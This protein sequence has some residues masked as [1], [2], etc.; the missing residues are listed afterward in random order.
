MR[1]RSNFFFALVAVVCVG[2]AGCGSEGP[3]A[4]VVDTVPP[5]AVE[6]VTATLVGGSIEVQW[7]AASEADVVGYHVFRSVNGTPAELLG[8]VVTNA[9]TDVSLGAG[10]GFRYQIA[11]YDA[12]GNIGVTTSSTTVVRDTTTGSGPRGEIRD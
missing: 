8:S 10:I 1:T 5:A 4:V 6:D 7:A 9:Y 11:A 2:A 12:A 3:A